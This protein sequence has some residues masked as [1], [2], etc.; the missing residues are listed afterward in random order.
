MGPELHLNPARAVGTVII[1]ERN[2]RARSSVAEAMADC[3]GGWWIGERRSFM[4][5]KSG[6]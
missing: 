6:G 4:E 2:D 3:Y 1:T 5:K